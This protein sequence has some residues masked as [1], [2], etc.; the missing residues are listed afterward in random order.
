MQ[1]L[2]VMAFLLL[3]MRTL[4]TEMSGTT[5]FSGRTGA[6]IWFLAFPLH[7]PFSIPRDFFYLQVKKNIIKFQMQDPQTSRNY[8]QNV[9]YLGTFF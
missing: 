5:Q 7:Y 3:W 4:K 9:T 1:V 6:G 2:I 8:Q